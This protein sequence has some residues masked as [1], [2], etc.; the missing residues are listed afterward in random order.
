MPKN[1][2]RAMKIEVKDLSFAYEAQS[3]LRGVSFTL[4]GD[5]PVVLLG[6]SGQGKT[7]LLR[8][9]AGLLMPQGG[10]IDGIHA[11][12]RIAVMFQEDRLFP[13]MSVWKNLKLIRPDLTRQQAAGMLA[14]LDLEEKVLEQLPRELSGGMRRRIAL[15]RALLFEAELVLMDEPFQGL[16]VHTRACALQAVRKWTEG[17]PL[18]LISHEADDAQALGARVM[19]LEEIGL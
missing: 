8:L 10:Q 6:G 7:T 16:D 18:L 17:R 19:K 14:E 11:S 13:Q 4:T 2:G 12:T 15:A 9:L 1:G 5:Q 3:V